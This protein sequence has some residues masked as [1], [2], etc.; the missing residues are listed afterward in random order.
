MRL[1]PLPRAIAI[2]SGFCLLVSAALTAHAADQPQWGEPHTRNMISGETGLPTTFDPATG[3]NMKWTA[4]LGTQAFGT[5]TIA[6]GKIFIGANNVQP[7]DPRHQGDRGVF[8]CLNES[9][10]T[11][12][13]Q[14][15][16]PRISDDR[17]KDWPEVAPSSPPTVEGDRVYT[18]TNRFE[19]VCFDI[20]GLAN[21]NDGPF[22]D[23][24]RHMVP[25]DQ[26]PME[27]GPLDADI[28]WLLD[29]PGQVGT[30]PHDGSHSSILIDGD[31]LYVN[32]CNGVDN[33][34]AVMPKPDAPNL[35]VIDKATGR[36][37][38]QDDQCIS[39]RAQHSN[40]S[41]PAMGTINGRKQ[42][43]LGGGD[44]IV[45]AFDAIKEAPADGSVATL[46]LVWK[47]DCDPTAPKENIGTYLRNLQESPSCISGMPVLYKDRVYVT[48]GGDIWWGKK[49][50][51]LKCIDATKTGDI[52]E[53]GLIWSYPLERHTSSTP[54]IVNGLAFAT[55]CRGLVHCVDAETGQ[56]Y[57]T[58]RMRKEMWGSTLAA[59]G[60]IYVGSRAG[61]FAV[62][63]ADKELQVLHTAQ[64]DSAISSTPVAANGVLYIATLTKLY[65][66]HEAK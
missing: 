51:W 54:A 6:A 33:T 31:Y 36:L 44:G 21:G 14:S 9:D 22:T 35:I 7:R 43:I 3:A 30:Y 5:P 1:C 23:E 58:H 46:N 4:S 45:Y 39:R 34:H 17:Y 15:V 63:R 41:S 65:A 62:L 24:G 52:T 61:D 8:L 18:L 60:R 16:V 38:A 25:A 26:P 56:P 28:I 2:L 48:V 66:I 27:T 20:N 57:W 64:L 55:D 47:F 37:V 53:T 10:G 19:V 40:W 42:I 11:L 59:D 49:F 50:S 13:W 32:T 29:M 12:V